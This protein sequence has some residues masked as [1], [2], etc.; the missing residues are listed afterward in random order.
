MDDQ[1]IEAAAMA[2]L[3][4]FGEVPYYRDMAEAA[5][6]AADAARAEDV[7]AAVEKA[8]DAAEWL[9]GSRVVFDNAPLDEVKEVLDQAIELAAEARRDLFAL[10]GIED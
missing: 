5:I 3:T 6:R 8:M 2:I 4:E 1:V 7:K 10:L 9:G